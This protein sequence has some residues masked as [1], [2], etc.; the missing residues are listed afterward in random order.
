MGDL[1][2]KF[3]LFSIFIGANTKHFQILIVY[4]MYGTKN[5]RVDNFSKTQ[6]SY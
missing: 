6:F 1:G 5:R 3:K 4:K 2:E